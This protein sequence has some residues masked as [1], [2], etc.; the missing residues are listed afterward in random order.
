MDANEREKPLVKDLNEHIICP[1]CRGYFVDATTLVECLHSFCRGCIVRRL[2]NGVRACPVCN[3]P[4]LPPLFPDERLQRLVYLIVPGLFRSELERRRHF[5]IV[6]PQ[7]M[8]LVPPVGAPELTF[9]DLVSLSLSEIGKSD[10]TEDNIQSIK[11]KQE[12]NSDSLKDK[13][14]FGITGKT[15]YLKCPAGVT[16]RHLQRL[17]ML[18][19]GWDDADGNASAPNRIEMMYEVDES[20]TESRLQVLETSWTLLDLACIFEWKNESPM[21]LYYR[22]VPKEELEPSQIATSCGEEARNEESTEVIENIQRPPTPPP[23]PKPISHTDA[24]LPLEKGR[25][26]ASTNV[27]YGKEPE[28]KKPRCEVTPVMR[29]PDPP[30][31]NHVSPDNTAKP[32][33]VV[34]VEHHKRRKRRNK[35]VIAEITTMPREDLLKLKVR[36]TPCPPRITSSTNNQTKEKLLKMRAVRREKIKTNSSQQRKKSPREESSSE[37][38]DPPTAEESIED[39]IDGI[40]DEIVKIA[41]NINSQTKSQPESEKADA[42][43][44]E[45]T[46][47]DKPKDEEVLR[48]LGLVAIKEANKALQGRMKNT[49][50]NTENEDSLNREKL[51]QQLRESKANRVRSLLAEKQMRDALKSMMS[52]SKDKA[53]TPTVA[54]NSKRKGPPPLAPLRTTKRNNVSFSSNSFPQKCE[55]PLDLSSSG[56]VKIGNILDLSSSPGSSKTKSKASNDSRVSATTIATKSKDERKSQDLNLRTLSDAAVSLLSDSSESSKSATS[57]TIIT[58]T[59]NVGSKVSLR[60]PQPHQRIT[61][62]GQGD[63]L[64]CHERESVYRPST[65]I[66]ARD[67]NVL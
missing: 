62:F 33:K 40:P 39:I 36:L 25:P 51:E 32:G 4:T 30:G 22:V 13:G 21:K 1:L 38:V 24:S 64:C 18:K 6:N 52:N 26:H 63:S 55:T 8:P 37:S 47:E 67:W 46:E 14:L 45:P 29:A 61:G 11:G 35:R 48:R 57:N 65:C 44:K 59:M 56:G 7:C 34:K 66:M 9:D 2:S 15:R 5:R 41:Q 49:Q 53:N 50:S 17:L 27:E 42:P 10:S 58:G 3:V 16:V 54:N 43:N 12:A 60:I 20:E 19:R 31:N 23:S 28:V